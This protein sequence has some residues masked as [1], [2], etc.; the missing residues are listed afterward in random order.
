MQFLSL[1]VSYYLV[2]SLLPQLLIID[3]SLSIDT[4]MPSSYTAIADVQLSYLEGF[5]VYQQSSKAL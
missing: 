4:I 5:S 1:K 3:I 2:S